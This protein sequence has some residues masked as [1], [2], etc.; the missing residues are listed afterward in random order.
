MYQS[1]WSSKK[2]LHLFPHWNWKRGDTVDVWA[3]YNHAD[4]VE[5][6]LNGRSLGKRSPTDS[7]LH[8]SWRVPWAAGVLKA[9][10]YKNGKIVLERIIQTAGKPYRIELL[11]SKKFMLADGKD[12]VFVT[13][14]VVDRLGNLVPDANQL[15]EFSISGNAKLV[16]TDNGY[17]ADIRSLQSNRRRAWKGLAMVYLQSNGK[18]G[19]ITL[20]AESKGLQTTRLTLVSTD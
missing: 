13:A 11:P 1:Q 10:S 15:L 14:R 5:L 6:F 4:H 16:G 9:R 8:V 3:Y 7:A 18:K 2:V 17:Q 20:K 19:N 12:M